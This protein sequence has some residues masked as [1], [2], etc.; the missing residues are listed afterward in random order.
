MDIDDI[1]IN[2]YEIY[3]HIKT[4][5]P[6][7]SKLLNDRTLNIIYDN[8]DTIIKTAKYN[9]NFNCLNENGDYA[10]NSSIIP[11][12]SAHPNTY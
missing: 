12:R 11:P 7:L 10:C 8:G 3:D 2:G 6:N 1:I 9:K 4:K 5:T